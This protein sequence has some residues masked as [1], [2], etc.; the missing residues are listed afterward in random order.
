MAER[1][2]VIGTCMGCVGNCG[3]IYEVEE[4]KIVKIRGNPES[5]LT[6]GHVCP[7]G[8]AIEELRS[9]PERLLY[10]LKRT[11]ERGQGKW[12]RISWDE[13]T[14]EVADRLL[15][16]KQVYGPE[17]FVIA[18][19]FT[20]VIAGLDPDIGRF[21]HHFGSPNRLVTLHD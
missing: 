20:G 12:T 8:L 5:P 14:T 6:K 2:T 11:G 18:I 15:Q 9:N 1:K 13:A 17:A 21:L 7:K 4:N 10:P 19:G 16:V 3:M